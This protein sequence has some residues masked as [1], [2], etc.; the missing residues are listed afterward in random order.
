MKTSFVTVIFILTFGHLVEC[1]NDTCDKNKKYLCGD[2]CLENREDCVCGGKRIT[3]GYLADKYCCSP[4]ST[5]NITDTGASCTQGEVLSWGSPVLCKEICFTSQQLKSQD[6]NKYYAKYKCQEKCIR[7][8]DM[9]QGL[10]CPGDEEACGPELRCPAGVT[11]YNMPTMPV[12]SYCY[13]ERDFMQIE[14]NGA[15]DF[16]DRSD[17]D[18]TMS[19]NTSSQSINYTAL[20]PCTAGDD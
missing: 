12:R 16:L 19:K 13:L 18:L 3:W 17:E 4:A 15:Y 6:L 9:C 8:R 2:I 11:Q 10:L 1:S 7:W 5:C 14:N 20:T